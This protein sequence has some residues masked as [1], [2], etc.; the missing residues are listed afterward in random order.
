MNEQENA[1]D[2]KTFHL[3]CLITL[4]VAVCTSPVA[5]PFACD[6]WRVGMCPVLS[7]REGIVFGEEHIA[8]PV[9]AGVGSGRKGVAVQHF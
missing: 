6:F 8:S 2:A 1:A 7:L 3:F 9:A 4:L 5:F